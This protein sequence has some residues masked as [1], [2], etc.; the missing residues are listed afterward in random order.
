MIELYHDVEDDSIL[1]DHLHACVL[2]FCGAFLFVGISCLILKA[3]ECRGRPTSLG[4]LFIQQTG[5][6]FSSLMQFYC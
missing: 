3:R 5:L 1:N 6:L 4:M 2:G